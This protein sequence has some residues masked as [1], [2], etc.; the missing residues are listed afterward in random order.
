MILG[1]RASTALSATSLAAGRLLPSL[2][3]AA[4]APVYCNTQTDAQS[5]GSADAANFFTNE[6]CIFTGAHPYG[7]GLYASPGQS[8]YN[9]FANPAALLATVRNPILGLDTG[10]GGVGEIRG[11]MYWNMDMRLTKDN[12]GLRACWRPIR[13]HRHQRIQPSDILRSVSQPL[14]LASRNLVR[15]V[16]R[17]TT[18]ARCSSACASRS[19]FFPGVFLNSPQKRGRPSRPSPFFIAYPLGFCSLNFETLDFQL[20]VF[21]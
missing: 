11:Q 2:L 5:F 6:Q 21:S 18:R 14:G 16:R 13:V 10:T 7:S 3:L 20:L 15:S 19:N 9:I 8:G 4:A 12:Q 17:A 1:T